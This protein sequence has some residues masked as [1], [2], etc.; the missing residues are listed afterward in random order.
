MYVCMQ[1]ER[2]RWGADHDKKLTNDDPIDIKWYV[3][4]V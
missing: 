3:V 4:V 1:E 2:H